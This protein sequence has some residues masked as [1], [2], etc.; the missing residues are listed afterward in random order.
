MN[1]AISLCTVTAVLLLFGVAGGRAATFK[2]T[3]QVPL[4]E[5][6]QRE[7]IVQF[8]ASR[9]TK[10]VSSFA[11]SRH[12]SF[13]RSLPL[14]YRRYEILRV[15]EGQDYFAAL[16]EL[17]KDPEVVSATPNVIKHVSETVLNDPLLFNGADDSTQALQNPYVKND[18]WALIYKGALKA[19]DTTTGDPHVI[20]AMLDTGI[21]FSQEDLQGR[22]WVNPGEI[23][24]NQIDDDHNGFVDDING[25]DFDGWQVS[26][27]TGGDADPSD[28]VSGD[29]SHGTS[30][31][32]IVAAHGNNGKGIAGVAGGD[33]DS[34]GVRLMIC[35]VGTNTDISV[36]AE[37]GGLDYASQMGAKVIS[38]SFG[39]YSGGA[40]EKD[41]IDRAWDAGVYIV[42][43][44]GNV[45]QGNQSG[46]T[47]LVDLPAGFKN[48]VAVGATTIFGSQTV[49]GSTS[50]IDE[51]LASYTKTG[52]EMEICAPGTHIMAAANGDNLYTDSIARQFTG[53]SAAT[54][55]VAGLA[56]LLL[57]AD[58]QLNSG[59]TLTNQDIRDFIDNTALDLGDPGPDEQ[60]G[61]GSI[62]M[63]E[64]MKEVNPN[65]KVGDTNGDGFIDE[66]DVQPIID[67]FGSRAGAPKYNKRIDTNGDGF[68]DELDLFLVG[69]RFGK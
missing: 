62:Q 29:A 20:V 46:D 41:A 58:Y 38:M 35:R 55:V 68:I 32:S 37:I 18:Q 2:T 11:Q 3:D 36:D 63:F 50:I 34:N 40:P 27:Q 65:G 28:P 59:F 53:T 21:N 12:L 54:P 7:I 9:A 16:S 52:P 48:C 26:S 43:A 45:G 30:T 57:S 56:A 22:I 25:Y 19:W 13:A 39:G 42:A 24:G 51:T 67:A 44:S 33:S 60:Y 15:P 66:N 49:A 6:H 23:P 10:S 5:I 1:K 61:N 17:Q 8:D 31:A 4:T 64:A 69:T 14:S 47:W